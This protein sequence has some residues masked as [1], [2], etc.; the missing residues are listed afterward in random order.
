[1]TALRR[2]HHHHHHHLHLW[3]HLSWVVFS[4]IPDTFFPL[5]IFLCA[6]FLSWAFFDTSEASH[7]LSSLSTSSTLWGAWGFWPSWFKLC[8]PPMLPSITE[9]SYSL[10]AMKKIMFDSKKKIAKIPHILAPTNVWLAPP[11]PHLGPILAPFWPHTNKDS[12]TPL[13]PPLL[14]AERPKYGFMGSRRRRPPASLILVAVNKVT[15]NIPPSL[16]CSFTSRWTCVNWVVLAWGLS[17]KISYWWVGKKNLF[18]GREPHATWWASWVTLLFM[19]RCDGKILNNCWFPIQTATFIEIERR[20]ITVWLQHLISN[21][22][23][24]QI[25]HGNYLHGSLDGKKTTYY[26]SNAKVD[27]NLL[28]AWNWSCLCWFQWL[29]G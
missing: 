8:V 11:W 2:L 18:L 5:I 15:W 13:P 7:P 24:N 16:W 26:Q 25:R 21:K 6:L 19:Q 3:L 17:C 10:M 9:P 22:F 1:M 23:L 29:N 4:Y 28:I 27:K 14:R 20:A 12:V